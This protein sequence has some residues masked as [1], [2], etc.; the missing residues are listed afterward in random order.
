MSDSSAATQLDAGADA[1]AG[2]G[3]SSFTPPSA[4]N[5]GPPSVVYADCK[6]ALELAWRRGLSRDVPVRTLAPA[7]LADDTVDCEPGDED[8]SS[9][10]IV[11]IRES[12]EAAAGRVHGQLVRARGLAH[13][14]DVALLAANALL[15]ELQSY[16]FPAAMLREPGATHVPAVVVVRHPTPA[17]RR[18]FQFALRQLVD[19]DTRARVIE[20]AAEDLPPVAEPNPP[21][22]PLHVRLA[23]ATSDS[24]LFRL[25]TAFWESVPVS[26]PRGTLLVLGGNELLKETAV[27]LL[28][29]GFGMR[30]LRPVPIAAAGSGLAGE[31]RLEPVVRSAVL[32][33][34]APFFPAMTLSVL[35][36]L[37][38]EAA[39]GSVA[40]FHAS[41]PRWQAILDGHA[42][43]H[44]R[45]VLTGR[46]RTPEEVA[47]FSV[48]RDRRL[49]LVTFQHGVTVEIAQWLYGCGLYLENCACDLAITFNDEMAQ[50][51]RA[52]PLGRGT[53]VAVGMPKDYRRP[54]P[55]G[56]KRGQAPVWYVRNT[57][58]QGNIGRLH[59]GLSDSAMWAFESALINRVLARLA[60]AVTYKPYP[61]IRYL[62]PDPALALAAQKSNITVYEGRQDLRYL[63][64]GARVLVTAGAT[65]TVS[66]CLM[67]NKPTVFIDSQRFMP[68]RGAVREAFGAGLFLFDADA[69]D[70]HARLRDF[71][72]QP[73]EAI[74]SAWRARGEARD[75][76][77]QSFVSSDRDG[78]G[79]GAAAAAAVL[80]FLAPSQRGEP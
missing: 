68:L 13:A 70:F 69:P 17:M 21:A 50:L 43:L 14:P 18:R 67:S 47:L 51:C 46:A 62:D 42:R 54:A 77:I 26:G 10:R 12:L 39:D 48:L 66:W 8:L 38:V 74:E 64:A 24:V 3:S 11:A 35:A 76:L 9:A 40:R 60:H 32:D 53:A 75:L 71:L 20:I 41:R 31:A 73:L 58:Y 4:A 49:P 80:D 6:A 25:G 16:V 2:I 34:L 72:S 57:L 19:G 65:S 22:P 37:A 7:I 79:A 33:H 27:R 30:R 36:R 55:T 29:R 78:A 52:N 1:T 59:R 45:A 44:P 15:I 28:A 5:A 23:H 56:R 61:A 63:L